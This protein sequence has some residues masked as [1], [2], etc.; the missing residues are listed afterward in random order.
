MPPFTSHIESEY[1]S[2]VKVIPCGLVTVTV[3]GICRSTA[4]HFT[5]LIHLLHMFKV[6]FQNTNLTSN[7]GVH[8]HLL[9]LCV[10][11]KITPNEHVFFTL[12][13]LLFLKWTSHI[14]KVHFY[15]FY[16]YFWG[17]NETSYSKD[18]TLHLKGCQTRDMLFTLLQV[19]SNIF[20]SESVILT[21]IR[22]VDRT[23][24]FLPQPT[25]FY[26]AGV[27]Y[28]KVV[29]SVIPITDCLLMM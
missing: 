1:I 19:L 24:S 4:W 5:P 16:S 18:V 14:M 15:T 12:F 26:V 23:R 25:L 8:L 3:W 2:V 6:L 27:L 9:L 10:R 28:I 11:C 7:R 22:E 20:R 17:V 13:L 29:H 21:I